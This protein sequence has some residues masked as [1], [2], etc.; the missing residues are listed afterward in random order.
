MMQSFMLVS[1]TLLGMLSMVDA[2][3]NMMVDYEP[4]TDVQQHSYI[5]LDQQEMEAHL[6][7]TPD[8][9]KAKQ[10]YTTGAHSGA[11]AEITV[12]ALAE[13]LAKGAE[14]TQAANPSARGYLKKAVEKDSTTLIVTY[15]SVCKEGATSSPDTAGCFTTSGPVKVLML[16]L[17]PSTVTN[18][19]RTLAGFSTAAKDKMAGQE[20]YSAY[21]AYYQ[22]HDYAHRFVMAALDG[23][24]DF[25][26]K[27]AI[28]RVECAKKG[29]AYQNVWMYVIRE[30]EDAIMD[31]KVG[32]KLCNEDPVHAWDEAVAF[33]AGSLEGREGSD[34]GKLLYRLAEKRCKNFGTC[35]GSAGKSAVN[36]AIIDE[37]RL[38][39]YALNL[40]KCVEAIPRKKRIVELM[41]V[42]LVQGALRYAYK[43]GEMDHGSK[44]I[45]EGAAFAAAILPRIA[46]CDARA[47]ELI[48]ANMNVTAASPMKD[49]F[50]RVKQTFESTYKCLGMTCADVGGLLLSTESN[51]YYPNAAPC[52]D[53]IPVQAQTTTT[54]EEVEKTPVW[55]IVV[56]IA[57]VVCLLVMCA[58]AVFF[59][60]RASK[61]QKMAEGTA[62]GKGGT[63]IGSTV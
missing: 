16:S 55:L 25:A 11:Y 50:A 23:I 43:V 20:F 58:A 24:G 38:G 22:H 40:G 59:K 47:A 13:S 10:I 30:M 14:V 61:Y 60:A 35:T 36:A 49:G 45:A 4:E 44:E 8:F 62:Q 9:S 53:E 2:S 56:L 37:F 48:S 3:Y 17:V 57:V 41:S 7:G 5:D 31:C 19:Y 29:S 63:P 51:E 34:S 18:K 32:C 21:R 28:F 42:P 54:K 1:S 27:D 46:A 26:N 39:Q 6:K 33:Y 15:T 12:P 52:S